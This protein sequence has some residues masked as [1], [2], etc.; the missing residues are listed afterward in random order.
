MRGFMSCRTLVACCAG[1]LLGTTVADAQFV[2]P[3]GS[4]TENVANRGAARPGLRVQA[5]IASHR[6]GPEITQTATPDPE[7]RVVLLEELLRN[8]FAQLN[9]F[10]ELLPG[11]IDGG[12]TPGPPGPGGGGGAGVND[13]VITELA[14]NGN[15]AFVE[16]LN[17]SPLRMSLDGWV[18]S[19]GSLVSPSLPSLEIERNTTIVVQLG[20]DTQSPEADFLMGFRLQNLPAGELALFDFSQVSEGLLPIENPDLMIDYIQWNDEDRERDPP[21]EQVAARANLWTSIDAIPSSLA[22]TSFRLAASAES[23][24][25]TSSG[26]FIVVDF[27]DNTL[28]APESQQPASGGG[29]S[30][31]PEGDE[32][33]ESPTGN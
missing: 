20:G 19:D 13:M 28:G 16:L 23:R 17:R 3:G 18:F 33:T 14:H 9:V 1:V 7:Y 12:G 24:D 31:S 22:A 32:P 26:D 5:G 4:P 6:F 25:S 8:L 29:G 15:V 30:Q 10:I 27:G 11:I 2:D 21:L